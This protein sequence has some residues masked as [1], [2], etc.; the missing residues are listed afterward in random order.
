MKK[1]YMQELT[2]LLSKLKDNEGHFI[3]QNGSFYE[4]NPTSTVYFCQL[5]THPNSKLIRYEAL[6]H[7]FD[8]GVSIALSEKFFELGFSIEE[9]EN[10]SKNIVLNSHKDVE[11]IADEIRLIFEE[12]YKVDSDSIFD[13]DD[14]I[15]EVNETIQPTPEKP[16][17]TPNTNK[18]SNTNTNKDKTNIKFSKKERNWAIA[19]IIIIAIVLFNIL[20]PDTKTSSGVWVVN[21]TTYVATSQESFREMFR[22]INNKDEQALSSLILSGKVRALS[23]GTE[24]FLV[25]GGFTNSVVRVKGST[26]E[27]WIVNEHMSQKR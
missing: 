10:Y 23:P 5:V 15:E 7:H 6:S 2:R 27:L 17:Y 16:I 20:S 8:E 3:I 19:I 24:L 21:Q 11:T 18:S 26:Q 22:Y 4:H 13:F 14:Q 12:I 9:G 1:E 25:R